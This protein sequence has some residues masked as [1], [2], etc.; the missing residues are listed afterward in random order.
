LCM[1]GK[2]IDDLTLAFVA[3]LGAV[4]EYVLCHAR[5]VSL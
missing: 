5:V 2:P 1:V 4:D 3:P